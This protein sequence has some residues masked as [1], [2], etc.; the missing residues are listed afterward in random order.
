MCLFYNKRCKR[1]ISEYCWKPS[2]KRKCSI[3]NTTTT[4]NY[5]VRFNISPSC[6]WNCAKFFASFTDLCAVLIHMDSACSISS[7]VRPSD[8]IRSFFPLILHIK[9]L[10]NHKTSAVTRSKRLHE[11]YLA[12]SIILSESVSC[13]SSMFT[14]KFVTCSLADSVEHSSD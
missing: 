8:L 9:L 12:M 14:C 2:F 13:T 1:M 4:S 6:F 11:L 7:F 10:T 3:V 5:G